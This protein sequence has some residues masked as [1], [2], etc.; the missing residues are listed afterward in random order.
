MYTRFRQYQVIKPGL[1][2][3]ECQVKVFTPLM[4]FV[5]DLILMNPIG[6]SSLLKFVQKLYLRYFLSS[7]D[8]SFLGLANDLILVDCWGCLRYI[9]VHIYEDFLGVLLISSSNHDSL[10]GFGWSSWSC[11]TQL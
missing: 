5:R 4:G 3:E 1:F 7:L 6:S 8:I 9:F 11:G 2:Y 10:P